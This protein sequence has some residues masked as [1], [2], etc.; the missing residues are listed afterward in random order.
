MRNRK[1][2]KYQPAN[3]FC[4]RSDDA[5][6]LLERLEEIFSR[7]IARPGSRYL[8]DRLH[9]A[10]AR[11]AQTIIE[12]SDDACVGQ[13]STK[14][15]PAILMCKII[16]GMLRLLARYAV[17]ALA[18]HQEAVRIAVKLAKI[19]ARRYFGFDVGGSDDGSSSGTSGAAPAA[20]GN[21]RPRDIAADAPPFAA[22][23]A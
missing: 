15:E 22:A 3:L 21:A 23:D 11:L 7:M 8:R 18:D 20:A 10:S 1:P 13:V 12:A 17:L 9:R 6:E 4:H 16:D 2:L 19:I 14:Y 5:F